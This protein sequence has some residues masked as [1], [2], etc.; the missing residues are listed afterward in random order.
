MKLSELILLRGSEDTM[1]EMTLLG[2]FWLQIM[3]KDF[4]YVHS[5]R[6]LCF[7]MKR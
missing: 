2:F 1:N 6:R 5:I 4:Q 3:G 7:E